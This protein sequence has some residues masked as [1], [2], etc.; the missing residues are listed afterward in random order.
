M[1]PYPDHTVKLPK[2]HWLKKK[3]HSGAAY[4]K[5]KQLLNNRHLHTVCEEARCPNIGECFSRG[6]ATFLILGK[7]CTRSCRFCAIPRGRPEPPDHGEPLRTAETVL[8]LG[9]KYAVITSVTRDDLPDGGAGFFTDTIRE[10]RSISPDTRV[11]VLV[12][13]FKGSEQSLSAVLKARPDVLNHNIETVPRLYPLARPEAG[14]RR[15]LELLERVHR[16][17]PA[18]PAKSGLMLGLGETSDE[19]RSALSDLLD[20]NTKILTLGQYLQPSPNHLPVKRYIHPEEFN[21]W[22]ETALDMGFQGVASGPLVRSSYRA[23]E[24]YR[25]IPLPA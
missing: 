2:P 25:A 14:Y 18:V 5:V 22:S 11:E 21:R 17:D 4:N 7:V 12:P 8:S 20:V 24:L 19:I 13:D 15:S 3:I 16:I 1:T 6:T 23:E 10:I 9:L